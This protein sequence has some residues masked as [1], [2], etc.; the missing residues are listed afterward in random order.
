MHDFYMSFILVDTNAPSE[1]GPRQ[2]LDPLC[3]RQLSSIPG[4][5]TIHTDRGQSSTV[6]SNKPVTPSC[7][8]MIWQVLKNEKMKTII[9]K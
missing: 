8:E 1:P 6:V 3:P 4:P 9:I 5:T 7:Q 2:I